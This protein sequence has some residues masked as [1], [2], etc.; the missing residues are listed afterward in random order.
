MTDRERAA[1]LDRMTRTDCL[2]RAG[3]AE[4]DRNRSLIEG[5]LDGLGGLAIRLKFNEQG[6][7]RASWIEPET[8]PTLTGASGR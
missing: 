6:I 3:T 2:I 8:R 7:V 4:L 1:D 5:A